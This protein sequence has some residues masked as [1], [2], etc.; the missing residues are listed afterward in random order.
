MHWGP[1]LGVSGHQKEACGTPAVSQHWTGRVRPQRC[2]ELELNQETNTLQLVCL[3]KGEKVPSTSS[4]PSCG[5]LAPM[6]SPGSK[7]LQWGAGVQAVESKLCHKTGP[8]PARPLVRPWGPGVL[9]TERE[10]FLL[11]KW[12][13]FSRIKQSLMKMHPNETQETTPRLPWW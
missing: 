1:G 3:C 6:W 8:R 11:P 7:S 2:S 13:G 4:W 10:A 5:S 9:E 12:H